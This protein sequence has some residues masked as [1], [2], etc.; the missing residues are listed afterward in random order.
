LNK[1]IDSIKLIL[2]H[3]NE[4]KRVKKITQNS[5]ES[6]QQQKANQYG[7]LTEFHEKGRLGMLGILKKL[8]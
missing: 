2:N 3:R 8:K 7:D 6:I 5:Q 1:L 4:E